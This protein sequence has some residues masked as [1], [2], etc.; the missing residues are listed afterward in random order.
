MASVIRDSFVA[1][2]FATTQSADNNMRCVVVGRRRG[3]L[4]P[5][6]AHLRDALLSRGSKAGLSTHLDEWSCCWCDACVRLHE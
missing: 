6:R 5:R 4:P 2:T 1:D 3:W